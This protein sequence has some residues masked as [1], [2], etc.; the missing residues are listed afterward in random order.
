[1]I[2]QTKYVSIPK[3]LPTQL[4]KSNK[5][6]KAVAVWYQLKSLLVGGYIRNFGTHAKD[7][8]TTFGYSESKL[9]KYVAILTQRGLIERPNRHDLVLRASKALGAEYGVAKTYYRVASNKLHQIELELRALALRENLERQTFVKNK[10]LQEQ[11]LR[12]N[13]IHISS[14]LQPAA[15]RRALR[16]YSESKEQD[17]AAS[18]FVRQCQSPVHAPTLNPF[19]TL[20]RAGIARSLSRKSK[21]TGHRYAAKLVAAGLMSEK[22]NHVFVCDATLQEYGFMRES[23]Y[24]HSFLYKN[25][26]VMKALSNNIALSPSL[27]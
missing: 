13:G 5:G 26:Q 25:G 19:V 12:D 6:L 27:C 14:N 2:Q 24:D 23:G 17:K 1:M 22:A 3:G 11:H 15:R 16:G 7:I 9:R 20:S 21:S 8:A 10:K 4:V 18:H